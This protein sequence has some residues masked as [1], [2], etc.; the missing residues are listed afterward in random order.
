MPN[1]P[2]TRGGRGGFEGGVWGAVPN[3]PLTIL[4]GP[5]RAN[6]FA[7]SRETSDSR[8]SFHG[9]QT[10]PLFANRASGGE[11]LRI[12][13]LRRCARIARTL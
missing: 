1:R 13:G 7:D 2:L 4:D 8:E 6:R 10:E 12:E 11:K 5:I 3:K 9:F